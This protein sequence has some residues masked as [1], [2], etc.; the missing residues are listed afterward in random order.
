[1]TAYYKRTRSKSEQK[2][3]FNSKKKQENNSPTHNKGSIII[4]ILL[5][6]KHGNHSAIWKRRKVLG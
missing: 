4:L 1:M 2:E 6:L 5:T 3:V